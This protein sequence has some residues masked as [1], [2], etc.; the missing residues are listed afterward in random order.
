MAA[1]RDGRSIPD[2]RFDVSSHHGDR[3]S[4]S[5]CAHPRLV[6]SLA[7]QVQL[8]VALIWSRNLFL[9]AALSAL[10][11]TDIKRVLAYS[12]I[13]QIGYMFLALGLGAWLHTRRH[14][15]FHDP[16]VLSGAALSPRG[17][18][19]VQAVH[20]QHGMFA[21]GRS[22]ARAAGAGLGVGRR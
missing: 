11:Q 8:A 18:V 13:S 1:G 12:T 17:A 3:R 10:T 15:S 20:H 2:K 5:H 4:L 6:L 19:R 14:V 16:R 22:Q 21:P 9:L 7:P